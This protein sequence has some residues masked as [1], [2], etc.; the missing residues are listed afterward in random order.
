MIHDHDLIAIEVDSE[1]SYCAPDVS[2]SLGLIVTELAIN[3]LK[4]AFPEGQRGRV[5]VGYRCNGPNW[6]LS[7]EDDGIGMSSDPTVAKPGLGTSIVE[8]LAR[9]LGARVHVES[10]RPGTRVSITLARLAVVE[11]AQSVSG[12]AI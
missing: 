3:A 4:H 5:L 10:A 7:V 11:P 12:E 6:T 8:A 2:I 9:Q 1:E